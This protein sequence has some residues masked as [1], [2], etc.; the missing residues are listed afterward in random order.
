MRTVFLAAAIGLLLAACQRAEIEAGK[1]VY[2][3]N[4]PDYF[5]DIAYPMATN[6]ITKAGFELGKKLFND[7]RL[8]LDNSIACSN[9]HVKAVAFTDPQHNPSVGIFEQSGSRNAPMIANM[10]FQSEFLWNGGVSH[11]DFVPVF[12]IENEKE[13]G[14]TLADVI[15]KLN[16]TD[17]YP[18]L[19]KKAF[20]KIDTITSP[21]MLKA[22]SQYMLLLVSDNSKY[23]QSVRGELQLTA[24]E[25]AG[26]DIFNRKCAN[27]HSGALFTNH[28]FLNNG[29]DSV[30]EDE[31][32]ALIS[33]TDDDLGK[34][35]VPGLRNVTLTAPYMHDGR[36]KTLQQVL[37]HY[38]SGVKDAPTLAP[39]LKKNG[40]LGIPLTDD[41]VEKLI[42][43]LETLTD[44][45]FVSNPVF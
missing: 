23:D 34:F 6:P 24:E 42:L 18:P 7:P 5:P 41:E 36:F 29:L 19:F 13:M 8:S 10:A 40:Q 44:Y 17:D 26:L 3:L 38:R 28:D 39:E 2:S 15:R 31:G 37:N 35:K 33:E 27:C 9:C 32:R 12:A 16:R 30:F 20:P 11:L 21:Y 1:E 25:A 14:E 4:K 45:D 22:L 43:F